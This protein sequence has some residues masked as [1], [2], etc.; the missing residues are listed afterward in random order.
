VNPIATAAVDIQHL[1][2]QQQWRFC[3]IGGLAVLRWGEPRFTQDADLTLITGFDNEEGYIDILLS[4]F[5][6]RLEN[7]KEFALQHR[8]LLLESVSGVPL[9]VSLGALPFEERTVERASTYELVKGAFL[10]T[11]S[12]EDLVVLKAF[13]GREKDWL[14]IEGI[15]SRNEGK[16]QIQL[17]WDELLPLL[18]LKETSQDAHRL[19]SL[20]HR[21]SA[22]KKPRKP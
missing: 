1:C 22:T 15:V 7:A 3:F 5:R 17:I 12:A 20:F 19:E 16:L 13:A 4:H 6:P 11:C 2:M 21:F 14:D 8:V 18:E 10:Q 9:D